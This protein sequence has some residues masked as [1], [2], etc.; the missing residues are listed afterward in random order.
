ML[1]ALAVI[2]AATLAFIDIADDSAEEKGRAFDMKVLQWLH[3]YANHAEP[4]GPV[5]FD[6]AVRDLTSLGSVAVL[7]VI[8]LITLGYLVLQKRRLEAGSLIV[9]LGGGLFLSETLKQVFERSRPAMEWHAT[10]SLN[11]SFPSGHALLSTV[12]YL[13]LG[14]M[15]ARAVK[16]RTMKAY[17]M[18]IAVVLALLVG[19]SRVYLGVHWASDVLGGWSLGA[20][21]ATLCWLAERGAVRALAHRGGLAASAGAASIDDAS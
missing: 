14:A 15:L 8:A 16:T 6:H 17:A 21:W 1:A 13:S 20:A 19:A 2:A 18:S 3:P 4:R 12:V 9:S 11:A 7:A 5:W 10:E